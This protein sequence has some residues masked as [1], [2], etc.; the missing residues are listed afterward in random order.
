MKRITIRDIAKML[1]VSP[2]TVSRALSN[3]PDISQ[4]TKD[5][6]N[7]VANTFNYTVNLHSNFFRNRKSNLIALILP[8]INMFF[9]PNLI[10]SINK[11]LAR[12]E[13]S[14][15]IFISK[16]SYKK[17]KEIIDQCIKWAVEGVLISLSSKTK[18]IDHLKKLT[19][20]GIQTVLLDRIISN[21]IYYSVISD[22]FGSGY[23]AIQYLADQG[24]RNILGLFGNPNLSITQLRKEGFQK[25]I[26][27]FGLDSDVVRSAT[28]GKVKELDRILPEIINTHP[29]I[30]AIFMMSDEMLARTHYILNKLGKKIFQDISLIAISDGEFPFLLHPNVTFIKDSGKKMGKKTIRL[31]LDLIEGKSIVAKKST[32]IKTKLVKLDSV[33]AIELETKEDQISK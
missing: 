10:R 14:L 4:K 25:A 26:T 31:L 27:D 1:D 5:R 11:I 20:F 29:D 16:D 8:E 22:S 6:V 17:E 33:K 12:T 13:Y 18:S 30:T 7:Q 24:H 3:H 32:L 15:F 2:S 9:T 28:V 23:K 19:D 21:E